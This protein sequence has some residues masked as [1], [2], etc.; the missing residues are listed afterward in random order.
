M[1]VKEERLAM[2]VGNVP[3]TPLFNVILVNVVNNPILS[4][5]GPFTEY[6]PLVESC[7]TLPFGSQQMTGHKQ[8][9]P[10][11]AGVTPGI[12]SHVDDIICITGK[13]EDD[14]LPLAGPVLHPDI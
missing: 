9:W 8:A 13:W 7:K 1:L 4:G 6:K 3:F 11:L 12:D 10:A 2:D 14:T 5:K